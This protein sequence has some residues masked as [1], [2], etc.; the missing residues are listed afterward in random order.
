MIGSAVFSDCGTYRYR[1][2]RTVAEA[3][4]VIAFFGVNGATASGEK[5]DHTSTKWQRFTLDNGGRRYIAANPFAFCATNVKELATAVDPVGPEND[6]YLE[7][8]IAEADL[9]VP[10]CGSRTKLPKSLR[11]HLDRLYDRLFASG[12]PIKVFGF[13]A[14]GDPQHP[15]MLPYSTKLVDWKRVDDWEP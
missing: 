5:D 2:D 4:I 15:L 7:Q 11:S 8:V 14:S 13:T 9:L 1:L 6:R 3:G 10:C 12:K